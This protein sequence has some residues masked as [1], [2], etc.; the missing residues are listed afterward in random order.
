MVFFTCAGCG[1]S[2][3]KCQVEKHRFRCRRSNHLTC[4]DCC[5]DFFDEDYQTHTK[6]ISEDQ[7]YGGANYVAKENK[8]EV[9]QE[10]WFETVQTAIDRLSKSDNRNKRTFD[11]SVVMEA[12]AAIKSVSDELNPP[13]PPPTPAK[14]ESSNVQNAHP[15]G[16]SAQNDKKRKKNDS[17]IENSN[18]NAPEPSPAKKKSKKEKHDKLNSQENIPDEKSPPPASEEREDV[19]K[20]QPP[21]SAEEYPSPISLKSLVKKLLKQSENG[22]LTL[23][24]LKKYV[25]KEMQCTNEEQKVD[26]YAKIDE[27]LKKNIKKYAT[28]GKIVRFAC[29]S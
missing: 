26:L 18:D 3:K 20:S 28:D 6:C 9:K 21:P 24:R 15:G 17:E 16:E 11:E 14:Q 22:E 1:E 5:K 7:K 13:K 23:K 27:F 8:G 29:K 4:I 10:K 25:G 19:E 12:W 2:L